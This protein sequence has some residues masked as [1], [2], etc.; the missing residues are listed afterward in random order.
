MR[1]G[2]IAPGVLARFHPLTISEV[3]RPRRGSNPAR[4]ILGRNRLRRAEIFAPP[5][6]GNGSGIPPHPICYLSFVICH[7]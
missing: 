7:L 3:V 2:C 6:W 4:Q 1:G 5:V